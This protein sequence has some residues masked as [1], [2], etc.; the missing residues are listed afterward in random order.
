MPPYDYDPDR[1]SEAWT[2]VDASLAVELETELRREMTDGH[3]LAGNE[4]SALSVRKLGKEVIFW[5][6]ERREW[7]VVHLTWTVE[8]DDQWPTAE[9]CSTWD[10]VIDFLAESDR[11]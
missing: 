7:A 8:S 6:P 10:D 4:L 1:L 5:L 11:A 3:L 2:E 9:L